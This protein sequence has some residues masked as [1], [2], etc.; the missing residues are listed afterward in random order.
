VVNDAWR[1]HGTTANKHLSDGFDA[2]LDK[3]KIARTGDHGPYLIKKAKED[4]GKRGIDIKRQK[5]GI[6]PISNPPAQWETVDWAATSQ[7]AKA[8]GIPDVDKEIRQ[9]RHNWYRGPGGD[10]AL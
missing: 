4:L 7:A 3:I 1:L 5:L 6:N 9:F 8:K 10:K 2:A